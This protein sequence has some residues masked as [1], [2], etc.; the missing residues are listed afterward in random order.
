MFFAILKRWY[1]PKGVYYRP[2]EFV[3]SVTP[4]TPIRG[5]PN[6][7]VT[8]RKVE[9]AA[10]RCLGGCRFR[11]KDEMRTRDPDGVVDLDNRVH[12]ERLVP[13]RSDVREPKRMPD[14]VARDVRPLALM[15]RPSLNQATLVRSAPL[16]AMLSP[17]SSLMFGET[18]TVTALVL[19][20]SR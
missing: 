6:T 17:P 2:V 7:R 3:V 10:A 15:F 11:R 18:K 8:N 20:T 9:A 14:F 12:Q 1:N 19:L 5:K 4:S 13:G 16:P